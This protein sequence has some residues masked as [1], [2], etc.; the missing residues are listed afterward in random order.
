M[1]SFIAWT[2][3]HY[4]VDYLEY[5]C[6]STAGWADYHVILYTAVPTYGFGTH[7]A[8]PD[9]REDLLA[10]AQRGAGGRLIW[11][12]NA[13]IDALT[14]H[15][16]YPEADLILEL[17]ADE[18]IDYSLLH[19]LESDYHA[20]RL[21]ARHYRLPMSHYWR[22]FGWRC[23]D[24]NPPIRLWQPRVAGGEAYYPDKA[25]RIHHFGYARTEANMRYKWDV[26]HHKPELRTDWWDKFRRFE[27]DD[28]HPVCIDGFWNAHPVDRAELPAILR[29]HPY[30]EKVII[31]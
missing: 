20:G 7:L 13:P 14:V 22:S 11:L 2:R 6:K 12:D 21:E 16:L 27:K 15:R 29:S 1:S 31:E 30:Y 19:A 3:V 25:G 23:E 28:V 18:V 10:A 9:S 8:N 26:S 4:G 24:S 17:D 5:V